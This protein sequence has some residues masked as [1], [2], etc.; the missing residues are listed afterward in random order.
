MIET[1]VGDNQQLRKDRTL[2][3]SLLHNLEK[4][5]GIDNGKVL[6]ACHQLIDQRDKAVEV[7]T[8]YETVLPKLEQ[9]LQLLNTRVSEQR[10]T[11][12]KQAQALAALG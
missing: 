4:K 1:L 7:V 8:L 2:L 12:D 10:Q 3:V 5:S 6:Q 11:I 9:T